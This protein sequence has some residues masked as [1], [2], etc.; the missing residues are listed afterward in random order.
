MKNAA[1][2]ITYPWILPIS[3]ALTALP[4]LFPKAGVL[5]FVSMIPALLFLFC[6]AE[7]GQTRVRRFYRYGFFY[8]FPFYL[9]NY[10][11]F[12]HSIR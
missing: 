12:L 2:L 7:E 3:A 8:F 10:Y 1:K 5:G 11:W 9:V 4:L 6:R